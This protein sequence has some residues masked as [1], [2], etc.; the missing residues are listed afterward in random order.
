MGCASPPLFEEPETMY[1]E[2]TMKAVLHWLDENFEAIFIKI[3]LASASLIIFCQVI[4]RYV[5]DSSFSWSE[6]VSRYAFIW[7]IYL[8]VS[9]AVKMDKHIRVDSLTAFNILPDKGKKSVCLL[10]DF[11]FL[12]FAIAIAK[13]GF[14]VAYLI[15]SRGQI[16]AATEIPMW[17]VYLAVPTGY[18]LCCFRLVQR[19][20]HCFRHFN[21]DFATFNRQ[22]ANPLDEI[23]PSIETKE[24]VCK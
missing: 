7:M 3:I 24:E 1:G 8:G 11:I 13:I 19:I 22:P 17:V 4:A 15:A 23:K 5:F 21:S 14:S 9:Y 18:S 12:G 2:P 6:E 10:A 20:V 16:T